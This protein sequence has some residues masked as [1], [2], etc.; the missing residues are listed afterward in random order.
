[1]YLCFELTPAEHEVDLIIEELL[2]LDPLS[3]NFVSGGQRII[4]FSVEATVYL[5]VKSSD[6]L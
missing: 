1:M 4:A 3:H 5:L 2:L 6:L